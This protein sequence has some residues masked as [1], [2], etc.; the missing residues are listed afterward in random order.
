MIPYS[1]FFFSVGSHASWRA[2]RWFNASFAWFGCCRFAPVH[3]FVL[4]SEQVG[5]GDVP[6]SRQAPRRTWMAAC[7]YGNARSDGDLSAVVFS[8]IG[9]LIYY[10]LV[11]NIFQ[12]RLDL[13]LPTVFAIAICYL[14]IHI[15]FLRSFWR[16]LENP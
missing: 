13:I 5:K 3:I 4:V 11:K 14:P 12:I 2:I 6:L 1:L 9:V 7:H 16:I 15:L 8:G 10:S